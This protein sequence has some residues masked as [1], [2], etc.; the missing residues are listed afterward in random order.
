MPRYARNT[1]DPDLIVGVL[2]LTYS[3]TRQCDCDDCATLR[4]E[5]ARLEEETGA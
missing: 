3:A 4:R 1:W 5:I 2:K